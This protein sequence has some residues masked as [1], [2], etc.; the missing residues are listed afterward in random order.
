LPG[1][2]L[3]ELFHAFGLTA[4]ISAT[5]PEEYYFDQDE[6]TDYTLQLHNLS[7]RSLKELMD[8]SADGTV[9][10]E[11][12]SG[13]DIVTADSNTFQLYPYMRYSGMYFSGKH[14]DEILAGALIKPASELSFDLSRYQELIGGLPGL[15]INGMEPDGDGGLSFEGSTLN[16]KTAL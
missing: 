4:N 13:G 12:L 5:G 7:H 10:L 6:A 8:V 15:P 14:V 11:V 9:D 16:F 3:H 2:M 1:T